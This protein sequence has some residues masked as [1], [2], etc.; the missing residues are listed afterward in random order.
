MAQWLTQEKLTRSI[1]AMIM[2]A[3]VVGGVVIP[4]RAQITE[5]WVYLLTFYDNNG[6]LT[7]QI[8]ARTFAL[9]NVP[10]EGYTLTIVTPNFF[11]D[12]FAVGQS[13]ASGKLE[14]INGDTGQTMLAYQLSQ[15]KVQVVQLSAIGPTEV[16]T[17][18][19]V[20]AKTVVPLAPQ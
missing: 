18:I 20:S 19:A 12:S 15:I 7:Q 1:T 2:S 11:F 13:I 3:I 5:N 10:K 8:P 4:A 14:L 9:N 6:T 17:T 16:D